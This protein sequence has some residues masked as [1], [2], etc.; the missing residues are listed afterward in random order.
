MRIFIT[1]GTGLIGRYLVTSLLAR[2][3][4][5]VCI[6][7]Q[8]RRARPLLPSC[9]E[10]IQADPTSEGPWQDSVAGCDAVVNLAGE[11]VA[12]GNWSPNRKRRIRR[13][14]LAT[15]RNAAGAIAKSGSVRVFVSASATGYYGDCGNEAL[16]ET[17]QPGHDWLARL[18]HEWEE[19]ALLAESA[20]TRVVLLRIGVVLAREGG[21]LP[22]MS[23]PFRFGLGGPIGD[24]RQYFP[25]IHI[26][27]LIRAILYAL[28]QEDLR[29]PA[30]A[31]A[32][33]P[34]TQATFARALG[35]AMRRPALLSVP[36]FL[37]RSLLGEK[38]EMLLA[39]QRAVPRALRAR[40]FHFEF[41]DLDTALTDLVG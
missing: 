11:S 27:D 10:V 30:N 21:A 20:M 4:S 33:D 2:G 32:P 13:S 40:G 1:G 7:R 37:L 22:K 6:S 29:G 8:E 25:W 23:L 39:S 41:G 12:K 5:V 3:D 38:S 17:R 15:T 24:G 14:R 26:R 34:P 19:N 28:D 18:A 35:R 16:D 9:A 31:V 36:A